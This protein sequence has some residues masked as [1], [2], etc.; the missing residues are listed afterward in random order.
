MEAAGVAT[1]IRPV[2]GR[3]IDAPAA[4]P[5]DGLAPGCNNCAHPSRHRIIGIGNQEVLVI[6]QIVAV[7]GCEVGIPGVEIPDRPGSDR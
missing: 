1:Q 7:E 3:R 5:R 2:S 6:L 4:P